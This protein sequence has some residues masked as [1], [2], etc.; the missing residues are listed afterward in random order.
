VLGEEL[1]A[2]G[3]KNAPILACA[4]VQVGVEF[5][6]ATV[7]GGL[8]ASVVVYLTSNDMSI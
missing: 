1:V 7:F 4:A 8:T 6:K 2:E 3:H 5:H